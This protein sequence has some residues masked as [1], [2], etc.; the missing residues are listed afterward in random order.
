MMKPLRILITNRSLESRG[1]TEAYVRDL[2]AGL[3]RRGHTPIVYST[4]LGDAAADLR[5]AT[6]PVVDRL[7]GVGA[8]PDLI[9]G[10]HHLETMTALL[11]FPGVPAVYF[12][13][14]FLPWEE[15][16]PLFPRIVR[17]VAVDW[18]CRD[19]LQFEHAVPE[20][21]LRVLLNAIDLER[22]AA[23]GPLPSRPRR[24]LVLSNN[25]S[26]RTHPGAVRE[27]CAGAGIE[28]AVVGR[29]AGTA[30][31]RP[32]EALRR[33]DLV[34][35]KGRSALEA[36]AVGAAVVL[37]DA[38]GSGPMVSTSNLDRLRP[39]NFGIRALSDPIDSSTLSRRIA[40]Y[41]AAD[42][43][44][45]CRRIRTGAGRDALLEEILELYREALD[46]WSACAS[47][48]AAA[49]AR[50]VADYLRWLSAPLERHVGREMARLARG[51]KNRRGL[52]DRLRRLIRGRLH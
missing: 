13:H 47:A 34:F 8:P 6:V 27:A 35:A 2:A 10:Q 41:D 29:D 16:P 3:L 30:S 32:E 42:A 15:A 1:G 26:E 18:T 52:R 36:L 40:E 39:L 46:E 31:V 5:A 19:R 22:F 25:A 49:E 37:C 14:G 45:V 51:R 43:A 48:G 33:A 11:R 50:A 7:D 9:H 44:E 12:C 28:V 20:Q 21:R 24:A 4:R 38:A 17:Y 23:R